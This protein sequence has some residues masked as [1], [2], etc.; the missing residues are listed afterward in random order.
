MIVYLNGK[1]IPENRAFISIQDHGFLYGD[2]VYETLRVKD[3]DLLFLKEHLDRL[4]NSLSKISLEQ[5]YS[6]EK[7][8]EILE[9]IVRRNRHKEAVVRLTVTRGV[10][11]HGLDP[12]LCEKPTVVI[13]SRPYL[14]YEERLYKKGMTLAIV[15]VRRNTPE[16]TPP[17][18]KSISCLNSVL[19]KI[20]SK[21]VKAHEALMLSDEGFLTE[22][23]ISNI[24]LVKGGQ[25]FTPALDG[26]QLPGVTRAEVCR[27]A[28]E[29]TMDVRETKLTA[30][31]ISLADEIF[32]TSTLLEV[33]P[34]SLVKTTHDASTL[35]HKRDW[36]ITRRLM[37]CYTSA[38]RKSNRV[39][40]PI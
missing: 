5:V 22:G 33:M 8:R 13:T 7:W 19:A 27:L 26:C 15:N 21:K 36:P 3:G 28:R 12:D 11:P 29:L 4:F 24:F 20:E 38:R 10:G 32:L 18:I 17:S 30:A 39:R 23:T 2:G 37:I 6:R 34:V 35:F 1:W 16:A 25:L 14:G 40:G 9:T 31:D